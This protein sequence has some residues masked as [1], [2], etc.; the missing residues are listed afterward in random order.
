MGAGEN[1]TGPN[2]RAIVA[3]ATV[4]AA[5]L[6]AGAGFTV[7]RTDREEGPATAEGSFTVVDRRGKQRFLLESAKPR[8][9][10]AAEHIRPRIGRARTRAT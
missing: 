7:G 9:Y 1:S 8:S 10:S 4:A 6:G 5:G 3:A 2:R